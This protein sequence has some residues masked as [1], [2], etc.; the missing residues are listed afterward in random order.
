LLVGPWPRFRDLV[1]GHIEDT[2]DLSLMLANYILM[3]SMLSM[4]IKLAF[5]LVGTRTDFRG[6]RALGFVMAKHRALKSVLG[7]IEKLEPWLLQFQV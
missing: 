5:W 7:R 2:F 3:I 1:S 6:G 4:L